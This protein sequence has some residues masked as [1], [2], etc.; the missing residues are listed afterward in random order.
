VSD[1]RWSISQFGA[2]PLYITAYVE[3][4]VQ[5]LSADPPGQPLH[6]WS[7]DSGI[8]YNDIGLSGGNA[9]SPAAFADFASSGCGISGLICWRWANKTFIQT[10]AHVMW[11]DDVVK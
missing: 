11:F 6:G 9:T 7:D 8:L 5:F 10:R 2:T 3:R 4:A 1:E